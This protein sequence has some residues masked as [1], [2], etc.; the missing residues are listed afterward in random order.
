MRVLMLL[1]LI[2]QVSI[3]IQIYGSIRLITVV[4]GY[5]RNNTIRGVWERKKP[6]LCFSANT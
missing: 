3:S 1:F 5:S 4:M 2:A 6:Y